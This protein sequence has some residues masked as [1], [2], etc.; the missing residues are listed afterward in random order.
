MEP[1]DDRLSVRLPQPELIRRRVRGSSSSRRTCRT[2]LLAGIIY[3]VTM[4]L[5]ALTTTY[6][7][8]DIRVRNEV[9][10]EREAAELPA[11]IGLSIGFG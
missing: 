4:S 6:V 5:I 7:Y 11:E 10:E 2:Q 3:A 1:R 9:G 8:C